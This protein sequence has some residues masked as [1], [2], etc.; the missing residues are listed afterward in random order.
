M[1][2][3]KCSWVGKEATCET[4]GLGFKLIFGLEDGF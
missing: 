2:E 1:G 4:R 3:F